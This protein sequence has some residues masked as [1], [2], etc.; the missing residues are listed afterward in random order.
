MMVY[1]D[2]EIFDPMADLEKITRNCKYPKRPIDLAH[3]SLLKKIPFHTLNQI[4]HNLVERLKLV[5]VNR[6]KSSM[7]IG[8]IS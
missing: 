7:C 2:P 1:R 3:A 4:I 6:D 5:G 8:H